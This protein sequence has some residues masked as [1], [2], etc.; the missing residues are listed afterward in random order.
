MHIPSGRKIKILISEEEIAKKV[1]SVATDLN[2]QFKDREL[3]IV[4]ILK[5]A[6]CF[7]ADLIRHL[8]FPFQL[9]FVS[10]ASYGMRGTKPGEL[11]LSGFE[12]LDLEGKDILLVDDIYDTGKTLSTAFHVIETKQPKSLQTLVLLRKKVD[13]VG[14]ILPDRVCF[15]IGDHF[16]IGY[17]LDYKEHFRG[18]KEICINP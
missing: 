16:V 10:A 13:H 5:G 12:K 2:I 9:E 7:V 6:I 11:N 18:L 4:T 14:N 8:E 17:G 3:I 1:V 15:D